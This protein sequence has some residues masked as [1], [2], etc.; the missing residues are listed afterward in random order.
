MANGVATLEPIYRALDG[1]EGG[2][3]LQHEWVNSRG[4]IPRF[5]RQ[6]LEIRTMDLQECVKM[7]LAVAAFVRAALKAVMRAR[8]QTETAR[9]SDAGRGFRRGRGPRQPGA[10]ACQ[11]FPPGSQQPYRE[12]IAHCSARAAARGRRS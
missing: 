9:T 11:A 7:D 2:K 3:R 8:R 1:V 12:L 6:A 5:A 10:G 4:V